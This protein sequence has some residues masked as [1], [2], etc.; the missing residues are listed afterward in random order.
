MSVALHQALPSPLVKQG[1]T[2]GE[3]MIRQNYAT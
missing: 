1:G 2:F 3:P